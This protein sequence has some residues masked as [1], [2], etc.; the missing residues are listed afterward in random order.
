MD[1]I[2]RNNYRLIEVIEFGSVIPFVLNSIKRKGIASIFYFIIN[3][4]SLVLLLI[5]VINTGVSGRL[6]F[7]KILQYTLAGIVSGTILIIPVHEFFHFLAYVLMGARKIRFGADPEQLIFYVTADRFP[8]NRLELTILAMAPFIAINILTFF[9]LFQHYPS[10][11]I[12]GG[13]MLLSHNIMCIGDFAI[14]NFALKKEHRTMVTFDVI[15]K[16]KSYF[17]I[18]KPQNDG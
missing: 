12:A 7:W 9:F 10:W 3:G 18:R 2:S 13:F 14:L 8:I 4:L 16:R 15:N 6:T 17:F 11:T 1:Q 5:L